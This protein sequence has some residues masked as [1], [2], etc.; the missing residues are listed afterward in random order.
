M[1]ENTFSVSVAGIAA[2]LAS[3]D[4]I[5]ARS[6]NLQPVAQAV[7]LAAQADVDERFNSS[8]G[9]RSDGQ[10]YGGVTW[11]RLTDAY[12]AQN[13]KR[14]GGQ[15]LRDTGELLNSFTVGGEGNVLQAGGSEITFGSALPKARGLANKRPLLIVHPDLVEAI[16]AIFEAYVVRGV[17]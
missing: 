4:E 15:Q 8:P 2:A 10:A 6:V 17:S 3:I 1:G 5:K 14:E 12:L 13:P 7:G 11:E 16:A 9:V